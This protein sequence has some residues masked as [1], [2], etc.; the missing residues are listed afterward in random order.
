[1]NIHKVEKSNTVLTLVIIGNLDTNN[2]RLAQA[3]IDDI[4]TKDTH[5]EIEVDFSK[6]KFLDSSGIGA[7]VYLYKRLIERERNMYIKNATGQPLEFMKLL[8]INQ[9]IS[10]S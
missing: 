10:I 6:V 1:M 3:C 9:A 7:L 5:N 8:R 2:S 4:L